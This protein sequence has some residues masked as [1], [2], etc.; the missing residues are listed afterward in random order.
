MSTVLAGISTLSLA[1]W[2]FAVTTV[3]HYL[4]VPLTIGLG[5]LVAIL[6]TATYRTKDPAWDRMTRFFGNL[7]L[8]NFAIGVVTGIVQEF[9]F[10]MDWSRYSVFVGNIFGAPLAIE[11]LLAFFMEST[12]LGVWIFGRGR[13]SPRIHLASIWLASLGTILSAAFIISANSW[14]QHPVGYTIDPTTH[15]AVMTNFWAVLTNP[16]FIDAY[17]HV[18]TSAIVTGSVFMLGVAAYHLKQKHDTA[19]FAKAAKVAVVVT[20]LSVVATMFLGDSQAKQ[21]EVQQPMKMAAAEALYNTTNGASFSLL[22]I[23]NLSGQPVFQIRIPHLLS[24]LATNSFNG[25]VEGI[26]QLQAEATA[27]Y[28]AGSYVPVI[29]LLYWSFRIMVGLGM[30]MALLGVVGLYLMRKRRLETS[31]WFQR[32]AMWMILA[33]FLANSFGWIFTEVGRQPWVVYGLLSTA[34]ATSTISPGYVATS[35]IGF[36]AIYSFLA[37]I[38]AGLMIRAVKKGSSPWAEAESLERIPELIY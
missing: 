34:Q 29:W 18:L 20:M 35:L 26:N 31:W 23:G 30:L 11:A 28:G 32:F 2:Q 10:G 6:Q 16:T 37:V 25:K 7:F 1:R 8:I 36:T 21:M 19:A 9:Q 27:K 14:M 24:V 3:F 4:F 33:P 15:Q 17:G 22:T 5:L 13:V 38:E 12:F